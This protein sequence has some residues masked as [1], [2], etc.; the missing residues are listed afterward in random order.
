MARHSVSA[1]VASGPWSTKEVDL[2]GRCLGRLS[3][4]DIAG[5][6]RG[7]T[8]KA[9]RSKISRL[10]LRARDYTPAERTEYTALD[11]AR[12]VGGVDGQNRV[13]AWIRSGYL[14][15]VRTG[16]KSNG[17]CIRWRIHPLHLEQF[18]TDFPWMADR[19]RMHP[20][21]LRTITLR[22]IEPWH[23]STEVAR[24]LGLT[25]VAVWKAI[26]RGDLYG[27]RRGHGAWYVPESALR[28]YRTPPVGRDVT[29]ALA[30]LRARNKE[31]TATY[32]SRHLPRQAEVRELLALELA[33]R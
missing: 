20:S 5:R 10:G 25:R 12:L 23:V 31:R 17:H 3:A 32:M 2:L 4:R 14:G 19:H 26:Q 9:V 7:R 30:A 13:Q 29:P 1:V 15:A 28:A 11:V 6:L 27:A 24:R 22:G 33:D 8:P 21:L 16:R 18:L